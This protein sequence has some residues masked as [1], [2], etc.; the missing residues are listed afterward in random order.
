MDRLKRRRQRGQTIII[1]VIALTALAGLLAIGVDGGMIYLD[2]RRL[3]NAA[4][5]GAL[6]GADAAETLP[7]PTYAPAHQAALNEVYHNLFQ[8][9]TVPTVPVAAGAT[10]TLTDASGAYYIQ[11]GANVASLSTDTYQVTITHA[12]TFFAAQSIGFSASTCQPKPGST[13]FTNAFC[14]AARA[15]AESATYPFALVLLNDQQLNFADFSLSGTPSTLVLQ[16]GGT[17]GGMFTNEGLG[18]G[19]N[20][21]ITFSPCGTSGDLWAA[22]ATAAQQT[23]TLAHTQGYY[24]A[25]STSPCAA[26]TGTYPKVSAHIPFPN[27]PE[28]KVTG[29]TYSTSSIGVSGS[30]NVAYLCPGTYSVSISLSNNNTIVLYPGVYRFTSS[31]TLNGG[32]FRVANTGGDYPTPGGATTYNCAGYSVPGSQP[33]DIGVILEFLPTSCSASSFSVSGGGTVT[34]VPSAKYNNINFYIETLAA[35]PA[36]A[37]TTCPPP[38]GK[39]G[40][41]YAFN[42]S[43]GGTYSIKGA[44]YGPG[45]NMAIGGNGAN[46]GVGQVIAW[47]LACSG[48]GTLTETYDPAYLPYFRGLVQ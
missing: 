13:T 30:G 37:T 33:A 4:D 23:A 16:S 3:Q 18:F 44:L 29:P 7:L 45:D 5:A 25:A 10:Y 42:L 32:T 2:K 20:P 21:V 34:L 19:G 1:L 12:Y 40:G 35:Y 28:A 24:G 27:Y 46:T 47:T 9:T 8:G 36:F 6:A 26:P 43:G 17:K 11:L 39:A 48:N 22:N 38:V 41:T 14:L 15:K 31:I